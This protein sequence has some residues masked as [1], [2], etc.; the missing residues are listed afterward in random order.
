MAAA[1]CTTNVDSH[2]EVDATSVAEVKDLAPSPMRRLTHSEYNHTVQAILSTARSPADDFPADPV[3]DGFD[4][5]GEAQVLT[6]SDLDAHFLAA[7]VLA[8]EATGADRLARLAPCAEGEE[9]DTCVANFVDDFGLRAWRRPLS[10]EE[11]AS[12]R[13]LAGAVG[14]TSYSSHISALVVAFLISPNFIFLADPQASLAGAARPHGAYALASQLSYFLWSG[15][16]DDNLL[17]AAADGSL[18]EDGVLAAQA[19]RMLAD[20]RASALV[21]DFAG[22]WM[23]LRAVSSFA[24]DPATFPKWTPALREAMLGQSRMTLKDLMG[25]QTSLGGLLTGEST[26]LS[27][28]LA[29]FYGLPKVA[30]ANLVPVVL[31]AGSRRGLLGQGA[32]LANSSFPRR[33]SLTRRGKFVLDQLL[34]APVPPPPNNVPALAD[35]G[36]ATGTQRTIMAAHIT[37]PACAVCHRSLDPYGYVLEGFDAVGEART[38][39]N[40]FPIDT[41]ADLPDGAQVATVEELEAHL[42]E[43]PRVAA[44]AVQKLYTY[45][46][47]RTIT[48]VD[49]GQLAALTDTFAAGGQTFPPLL[50]KLILSPSFRYRRSP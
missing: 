41:H 6:S 7:T 28:E 34:C 47:G 1:A 13:A 39:D 27:G 36:E 11:K 16:P 25:G 23:Q 14:E 31:P 48:D 2:Q 21:D 35:T 42:A 32:I 22:Q 33:T 5:S 3:A 10:A 40:N 30:D 24:P 37:Q 49:E 17:A 4:N 50:S 26:Y 15:P 20:P 46:L 19:T 9:P 18:T 45:A 29:A 43:D 38:L 12:M 44:C 8:Q